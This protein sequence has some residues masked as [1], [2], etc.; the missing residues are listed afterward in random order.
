[1]GSGFVTRLASLRR[2]KRLLFQVV[3]VA[4]ALYILSILFMLYADVSTSKNSASSAATPPSTPGSVAPSREWKPDELGPKITEYSTRVVGPQE[5]D[6]ILE[7]QKA[8]LAEAGRSGLR[9][10]TSR[11]LV[12]VGVSEKQLVSGFLT[13]VYNSDSAKSG[14]QVEGPLQLMP[15]YK[16]DSR[17]K[18]AH[19]A[20]YDGIIDLDQN[21]FAE[22][23]ENHL[24]SE[25]LLLVFS[26]WDEATD[27]YIALLQRLSEAMNPYKEAPQGSW[28]VLLNSIL[29]KVSENQAPNVVT[30]RVNAFATL[31]TGG[32]TGREGR[33]HLFLWP[34]A[35][36]EGPVQVIAAIRKADFGEY[37][38]F[39][40]ETLKMTLHSPSLFFC[41]GGKKSVHRYDGPLTE[42]GLINFVH[43][44]TSSHLQLTKKEEI[45]A[46]LGKYDRLL[47]IL[48]KGSGYNEGSGT[49]PMRE[50]LLENDDIH[51]KLRTKIPTFF[52]QEEMMEEAHSINWK[53]LNIIETKELKLESL[54]FLVDDPQTG[55]TADFIT[56]LHAFPL[57]DDARLLLLD[58]MVP[59]GESKAFPLDHFTGVA[60]RFPAPS[61]KTNFSAWVNTVG[62]RLVDYAEDMMSEKAYLVP[63][64][65]LNMQHVYERHF[66]TSYLALKRRLR[67]RQGLTSAHGA[68]KESLEDRGNNRFLVLVVLPPT[69]SER[70]TECERAARRA[71]GTARRDTNVQFASAAFEE[72]E[73]LSKELRTVIW[74]DFDEKMSVTNCE[75][76]V[77]NSDGDVRGVDMGYGEL[78]GPKGGWGQLFHSD[79]GGSVGS[80]R[81][82]MPAPRAPSPSVMYKALRGLRDSIS[83]AT[84][85]DARA[86][87]RNILVSA[88][89]GVAP[90]YL[91][92]PEGE[93]VPLIAYNQK[94]EDNR[95]EAAKEES[96]FLLLIHDSS[97]AA[98]ANHYKALRLL[99]NCQKKGVL[100]SSVKLLEY[101]I[102]DHYTTLFTVEKLIQ[103]IAAQVD[104][105][106]R[107]AL[108]ERLHPLLQHTASLHPPQLVVVNQTHILST[109]N[110]ATYYI[111]HSVSGHKPLKNGFVRTVANMLNLVDSGIHADRIAS[112][113]LQSLEDDRA[114]RKKYR[115]TG[116]PEQ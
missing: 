7:V 78:Q 85:A 57:S 25:M 110:T 95:C 82:C 39:G 21:A 63:V 69:D 71:A 94:V 99:G 111:Q 14:P 92:I 79:V 17:R 45:D 27:K 73:E 91:W 42:K 60:L 98:T 31:S 67:Q 104:V 83:K 37:H 68:S 100:P 65:G 3:V 77:F 40:S 49:S 6:Y 36:S 4:F 58:R 115:H 33:N 34:T 86:T 80:P 72:A 47:L 89:K 56:Q 52:V 53:A 64:S 20:Y 88:V 93:S 108:Y 70:A 113:M 12:D 90:S 23:V 81:H 48:C 44:H 16:Q 106:K 18:D 116:K 103:P 114:A 15:Y 102:S 19:I 51:F 2:R 35:K 32:G 10:V 105:A 107:T 97:C 55:V 41:S 43:A 101:D 22:A 8:A 59:K 50:I 112:C 109:L 74:R 76:Y 26:D 24:F 9:A 29:S 62:T 75:V 1:M 38:F 30:A 84:N 46:V 54:K 66:R 5:R 61:G 11:T 13:R 28:H 96:V 87:Y